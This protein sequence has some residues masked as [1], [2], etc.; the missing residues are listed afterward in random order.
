MLLAADRTGD[1]SERLD[2]RL[3]T[4]GPRKIMIRLAHTFSKD[5]DSIDKRAF[6]PMLSHMSLQDSA[7]PKNARKVS[8][9]R[10]G[11]NQAVRIPRE[12]E[13]S[14]TEAVILREEDHLVIKALPQRTSLLEALAALE[15]LEESLPDVD[16]S[17]RPVEPVD[18]P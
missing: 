17:L 14:S 15:P 11:A 3:S 2:P 7:I 13:L 5:L 10:N 8:L 4:L 12:F 6:T 18:L 1:R 9:F 16:S